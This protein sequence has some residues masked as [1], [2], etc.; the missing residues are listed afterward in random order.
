MWST[1][2]YLMSISSV[3]KVLLMEMGKCFY[4]LAH[5]GVPQ[6]NTELPRALKKN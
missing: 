3:K 4:K 1:I 6:V 2:C 5:A